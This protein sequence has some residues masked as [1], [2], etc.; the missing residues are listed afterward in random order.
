MLVVQVQQLKATLELLQLHVPQ[1]EQPAPVLSSLSSLLTSLSGLQHKQQQWQQQQQQ[2]QQQLQH[3][4]Q[5]QPLLPSGLLSPP[6]VPIR[7]RGEQQQQQQHQGWAS[8]LP[9]ASPLDR[10]TAA[11]QA[12][13][14]AAT[15]WSSTVG[16]PVLASAGLG[17][18]AA[19][20][21]ASSSRRSSMQP[22]PS[23][24]CAAGSL[25]SVEQP[26]QLAAEGSWVRMGWARVW[27]RGSAAG[28]TRL[29]LVAS[30]SCTV[31]VAFCRGIRLPCRSRGFLSLLE[32]CA[33]HARMRGCRRITSLRKSSATVYC[34]GSGI[35]IANIWSSYTV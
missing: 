26:P 28:R 20:A 14:D 16:A 1:Q 25:Q 24:S 3:H 18:P 4:Q 23:G 10:V 27:W 11:L 13:L 6:W 19:S 33:V 5:Q 34:A 35:A 8:S 12:A 31:E 32:F 2:Q 30:L 15:S 17:G 29:I 7:P 9:P 21:A 22:W